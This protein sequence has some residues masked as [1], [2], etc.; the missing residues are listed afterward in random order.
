MR[1]SL[2]S[3]SNAFYAV[4]EIYR[5]EIHPTPLHVFVSMHEKKLTVLSVDPERCLQILRR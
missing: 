1:Y 3:G 2:V 4:Y 5:F